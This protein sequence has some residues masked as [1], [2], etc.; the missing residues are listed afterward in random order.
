[1]SI[2]PVVLALLALALLVLAIA[3]VAQVRRS[4]RLPPIGDRIGLP[5]VLVH[6]FFGFDRMVGFEYFRG[7]TTH[8]EELGYAVHVVRLPRLHGVP[9]RAAALV[10]AIAKLELARVDVIAHSMGGLDARYAIAKLK[11]PVRTLVTI[12]TP[13][14]GTPLADLFV[15]GG[16]SVP[17]R[18]ARAIGFGIDAL[19][20]LSTAGA[21]RF[22]ADVRDVAG[23]RYACVIG[24]IPDGRVPLALKFSHGYIR[25][26]AGVNDG[27]VPVRS[28]HWGEVFAEIDADHFAQIGWRNHFDAL[29]LYRSIV[30]RFAEPVPAVAEPIRLE[31]VA[32]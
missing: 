16:L 22:N 25:R 6:G 4:R 17:R 9:A 28:Q 32:G 10:A 19:D 18:V 7:I 13:H 3:V 12:G 5:I 20:W 27:L 21:E 8:L 2:A 1:M 23:V 14:R 24:K 15:S 30:A 11:L 29:A 26:A 31:H